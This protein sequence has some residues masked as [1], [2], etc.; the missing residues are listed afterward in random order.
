MAN[1]E[2]PAEAVWKVLKK[3]DLATKALRGEA[4]AAPE[5]GK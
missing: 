5:F 2:V 3:A 4:V 1:K